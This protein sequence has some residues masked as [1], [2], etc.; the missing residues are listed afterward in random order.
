MSYTCLNY[1][2]T[3]STKDR[4]PFLQGTLVE[5]TCRY[6]GG[7]IRKMDGVLLKGN[8][9]PDH[10]HLAVVIPATSAVADFVGKVKSYASGWI[11]REMPDLNDFAWQD[12][13]AA[14]T[15]SPSVLPDVIDYIERQ[16]EH[17]A[18]TS[19]EEELKALLDKHGIEYDAGEL[20]A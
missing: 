5:R 19:F 2:V 3:F 8:G 1:H 9:Q 12:G 4:R 10:L 20:R 17:H 11:H 13:Y 6:I 15:V 16:G 18:T 14:L 7:M